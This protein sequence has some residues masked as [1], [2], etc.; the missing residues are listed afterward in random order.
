MGIVIA[1]IIQF[2]VY[3]FVYLPTTV[4]LLVFL[5]LAATGTE[6]KYVVNHANEWM[7][8]SL[9]KTSYNLGVSI[10]EFANGEGFK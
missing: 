9:Y 7:I 8:T 2:I 6:G 10:V 1:S 3:I 4:A 5:W